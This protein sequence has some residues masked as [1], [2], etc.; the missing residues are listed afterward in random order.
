[1][2]DAVAVRTIWLTESVLVIKVSVPKVLK[3]VT[4][5]VL[6]VV[7]VEGWRV[8]TGLVTV[9]GGST[10]VA[11]NV[12]VDVVLTTGVTVDESVTVGVTVSVC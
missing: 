5:E 7:V 2:H 4:V 6:G 1:M 11:T 12:L 10:L 8:V 9:D 3:V